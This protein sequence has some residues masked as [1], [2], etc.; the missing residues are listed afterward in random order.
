MLI[1]TYCAYTKHVTHTLILHNY[2]SV[3]TTQW[4]LTQSTNMLHVVDLRNRPGASC[5]I[6]SISGKTTDYTVHSASS[7]VHNVQLYTI[8]LRYLS[9]ISRISHAR[10]LCS[11]IVNHHLNQVNS[12]LN[13]TCL[14][15][16][17]FSKRYGVGTVNV[18][19]EYDYISVIDC[20]LK[21]Q[22]IEFHSGL[23]TT[24]FS[25]LVQVSH[26]D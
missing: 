25:S 21:E 11:H 13:N 9:G 20:R 24:L 14:V 5:S 12:K 26:L 7:R 18:M 10:T 3:H 1:S 4:L 17:L 15:S 23:V 2:Y 6:C 19:Y 22:D 16:H 8:S